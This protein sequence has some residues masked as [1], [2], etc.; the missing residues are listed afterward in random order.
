MGNRN[1]RWF[2]EQ[3]AEHGAWLATRPQR[4]EVEE[5]CGCGSSR[6]RALL[7]MATTPAESPRPTI[8]VVGDAHFEPGQSLRRA[9]LL[10]RVMRTMR[11]IDHVV[12]IG[13]WHGMTS[14]C[15]HISQLE[16]ETRRLVDDI[17]AGNDAIAAMHEECP[18]GTGPQCHVVL[19]NHC[20]RV[21]R[22]AQDRPEYE[23]LIGS[24]LYAW[25]AHGWEVLPFLDPLRIEGWRFQHFLPSRG[26]GRALSSSTTSLARKLLGPNGVRY[27]ESI[28]VGHTH[29]LDVWTE[30]TERRGRVWGLVAGCFFEHREDYA[31]PDS[32]ADWWRGLVFLRG[33]FAGDASISA[34]PMHELYAAYGPDLLEEET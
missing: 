22:L 31:G 32:N 4:S 15:R 18:V 13:D 26:N 27:S 11:P 20:A 24:H 14:A 34:V 25:E 17:A 5:R 30:A 2:R 21:D 19:G 6:A 3:L 8:L 7:R 12:V 1:R 16:R 29:K 9:R 23:G 33:A 10:G 28:V